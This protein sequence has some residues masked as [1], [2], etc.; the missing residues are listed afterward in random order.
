MPL[1]ARSV[2]GGRVRYPCAATGSWSFI[3]VPGVYSWYIVRGE[4]W[5]WRSYQG[6]IDLRCA[7]VSNVECGVRS[8][9]CGMG[10]GS[11]LYSKF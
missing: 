3:S 8:V 10:V 7:G 11:T 1:R 2:A 4:L 5:A 6:R 9:E